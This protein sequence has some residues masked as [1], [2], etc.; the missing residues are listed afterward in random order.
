MKEGFWNVEFLDMNLFKVRG[1][2]SFMFKGYTIYS[3]GMRPARQIEDFFKEH[4]I[5]Y[6]KIHASSESRSI[7]FP[8]NGFSYNESRFPMLKGRILSEIEEGNK[9]KSNISKLSEIVDL[10]FS[11]DVSVE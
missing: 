3:N 9:L 11:Y 4:G 2:F 10:V 8:P 5:V 6:R 7:V 1:I